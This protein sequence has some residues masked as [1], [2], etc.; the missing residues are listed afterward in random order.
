M[1]SLLQLVARS[2]YAITHQSGE[3][4][5]DVW[6]LLGPYPLDRIAPDTFYFSQLHSVSHSDQACGNSHSETQHHY[7]DD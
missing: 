4:S 5:V 1:R 7:A 2:K 3:P 6:Y